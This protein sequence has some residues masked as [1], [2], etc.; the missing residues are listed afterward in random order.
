MPKF[1]KREV[2]TVL[3]A[4]RMFQKEREDYRNAMP[5]LEDVK[6]MDNEEIDVLCEQINTGG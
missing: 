4:L 5:H 1:N 2:A 6:L 3:A